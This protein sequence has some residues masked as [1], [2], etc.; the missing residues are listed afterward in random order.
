MSKCFTALVVVFIIT[1]SN[2]KTFAQLSGN[3]FAEA[4]VSKKA[5]VVYTF[6]TTPGFIFSNGTNQFDGICVD[7]MKKFENYVEYNYGIVITPKYQLVANNYFSKMLTSVKTAKGGVFGLG[8]ITITEARNKEYNFS[9]SFM[10][11]VSLLVTNRAAPSLQK[12]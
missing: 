9:P 11:N 6:S 7:I 1:I 2:A 10:H 8:N 4:K 5:N 12:L 3:T